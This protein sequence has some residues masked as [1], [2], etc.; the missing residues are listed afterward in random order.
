MLQMKTRI[1]EAE[2]AGRFDE[3]MGLT[4]EL[5]ALERAARGGRI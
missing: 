2:R 4:V 3:A 1:S 5:Q